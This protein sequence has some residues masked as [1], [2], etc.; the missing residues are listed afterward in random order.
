MSGKI[1][2][3]VLLLLAQ[4]IATDRGIVVDDD[5]AFAVEDAAARRQHRHLANTVL[6]GQH[7]VAAG[8]ED[9]QP[10]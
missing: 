1:C 8:A 10:P 6:L 7:A 9:L 3:E 2:I 5:A 4:E